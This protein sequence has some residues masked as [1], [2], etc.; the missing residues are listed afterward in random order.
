MRLNDIQD[1]DEE[2]LRELRAE[3]TRLDAEESDASGLALVSALNAAILA[4]NERL[5][6]YQAKRAMRLAP[7]VDTC[8]FWDEQCDVRTPVIVTY[9]IDGIRKLILR[10]VVVDMPGEQGPC[11]LSLLSETEIGEIKAAL[12]D[13]HDWLKESA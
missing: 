4:R 1:F 7:Y 10:S 11:I 9:E 5:A 3:Q 8:T 13:L 2:A 6:S 12:C